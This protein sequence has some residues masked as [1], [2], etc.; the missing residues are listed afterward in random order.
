MLA[1]V[2]TFLCFVAIIAGAFY[3]WGVGAAVV[4]VGVCG[5]LVL[6]AHERSTG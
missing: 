5:L 1:V 6:E 4:A 3:E 2:L